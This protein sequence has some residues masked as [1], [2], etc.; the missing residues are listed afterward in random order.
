MGA[1]GTATLDFGATP[2]T[3]T[4]TVSVTGQSGIIAGSA[5][6]AWIMGTDSTADHNAY[7]HA[8][9]PRWVSVT[10]IDITP[11]TGFTLQGFNEIRL[12]GQVAV[13]WVWS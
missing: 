9:L 11:G 10:P 13:R 3:E 5:I 12:R 8:L 2:G 4:A 6:E 1:T 7:T